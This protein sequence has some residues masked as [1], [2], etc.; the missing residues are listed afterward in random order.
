MP[1]AGEDG[2]AKANRALLLKELDGMQ[3]RSAR[4]R[5]VLSYID[6][7][8]TQ[9]FEGVCDGEIIDAERGEEGFG[10]D[11]LF[12]PEGSE[13]TFAEMPPAEKNQISHRG[14]ALAKFIDFLEKRLNNE[15]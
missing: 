10:Y 1:V 3:E 7:T 14:R 5:T 6:G 13:L 8:T 15:I 11:P 9:F 2:N 12:V 4:F